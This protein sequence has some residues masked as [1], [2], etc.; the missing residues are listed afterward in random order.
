MRQIMLL[1]TLE[2][3]L[4]SKCWLKATPG[5]CRAGSSLSIKAFV[6]PHNATASRFPDKETFPSWPQQTVNPTKQISFESTR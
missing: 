5:S 6:H 1:I 2:T 4:F 3:C